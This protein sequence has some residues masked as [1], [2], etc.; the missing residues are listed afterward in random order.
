ME[1]QK[2]LTWSLASISQAALTHSRIQL[3]FVPDNPTLSKGFLYF[4]IMILPYIFVMLLDIQF[5]LLLNYK[6]LPK[7]TF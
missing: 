4:W 1:I 7:G 6:D 2:I 5:Q 3:Y